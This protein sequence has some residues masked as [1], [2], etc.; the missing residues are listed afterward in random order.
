MLDR[1][2]TW[3]IGDI[4]QSEVVRAVHELY[5]GRSAAYQV[6]AVFTPLSAVLRC[7]ARAG[8]CALIIFDKPKVKRKPVEYATDDWF[9]KVLPHCG[10]RLIAVLLFMT[11]TGA[12][13]S[14]ACALVWGDVDFSKAEA[15]LRMTK[16]GSPRLV[17]LAD[18]VVAA[19]KTLPLQSMPNALVFGYAGRW[20]VNQAIERACQRAGVSY[21]SSYKVGRH[22]FAARLLRAGHSLKLV[23]EAGGWRV[24]RMVSDHYGHLERS[25]ISAAIKASGTNLTQRN[26]VARASTRQVIEKTGGRDRDR[27][28]DPYHVKV[29]LYR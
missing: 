18:P 12:R 22:A 2:G 11:L 1:W 9:H 7:A 15:L 28:C 26:I 17:D 25:Q 6:R 21:L 24:A 20:S 5:P 8:L 16:G 3:R 14:E 13:V 27:T 19:L 10:P 4:T 29:V 23:Q